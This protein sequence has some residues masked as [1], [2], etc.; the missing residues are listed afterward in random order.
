MKSELVVVPGKAK[1]DSATY[2]SAI[3]EPHLVPF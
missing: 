3:M 1:L 2:A